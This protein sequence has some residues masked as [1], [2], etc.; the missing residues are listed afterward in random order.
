M[1]IKRITCL[2]L[3]VLFL[4]PMLFTGCGEE[5]TSSIAAYAQ[6]SKARVN[7]ASVENE[8]YALMWSD[9]AQRFG[10]LDK[11][12]G[13]RY[14][15]APLG[16]GADEEISAPVTIDYYADDGVV[17]VEASG[18]TACLAED[19]YSSEQIENG[20][21][22]VYSFEDERIAV[23]VEYL[24]REDGLEIRIPMDGIQEDTF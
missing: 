21:R 17:T 13:E 24:L 23:T 15:S 12:T 7:D 3:A 6:N 1:T 8:N 22:A 20:F 14:F 9:S 19:N 2:C 16:Y 4:M 10:L 11:A 5:T 18:A